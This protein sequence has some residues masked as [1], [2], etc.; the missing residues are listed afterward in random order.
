MLV[1]AGFRP[2]QPIK[3]PLRIQPSRRHA[4]LRQLMT[5]DERD[6]VRIFPGPSTCSRRHLLGTLGFAG[7]G[8]CATS[9]SAPGA[10]SGTP[11][12]TVAVRPPA[13][14]VSRAP[15]VIASS[16]NRPELPEEWLIRHG[17]TAMEYRR[18]LSRM[19]LRHIDLN[20]FIESHAQKRGT[21]WNSIPP[22]RAWNSM[23]Y[24]LRVIDRIARE[25]QAGTVEVISAYRN[26]AYNSACRGAR[27][28]SY[29]LQNMA[30]DVKFPVR[31]SK[32]TA[33]AR[34]LRDEGLFR[35]GVGGYWGFT[36]IDVRGENVNW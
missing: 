23:A 17:S 14:A 1:S 10:I 8:L 26:P 36:H 11:K 4:A 32:V 28:N 30:A 29:H 5:H 12:V 35:G 33:I 6:D 34:Q 9:N 20:Q 16:G 15:I 25:M 31:A 18:Y 27:A 19:R 3:L 2:N 21:T 13:A 7:I 24:T 22:K